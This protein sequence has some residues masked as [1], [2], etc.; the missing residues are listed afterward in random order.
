M[1]EGGALHY[2]CDLCVSVYEKARVREM[3][4]VMQAAYKLG[5]R[6]VKEMTGGQP[7]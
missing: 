5:K 4:D 7:C 1:F 2:L 6:A 3:P